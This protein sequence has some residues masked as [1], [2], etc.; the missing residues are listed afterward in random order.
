MNDI[1]GIQG[2]K[3]FKTILVAIIL[4]LRIE[5]NQ[6]NAQPIDSLK[7]EN[8]LNYRA[9]PYNS[10]RT[11][12]L[13]KNGFNIDEYKWNDQTI[14]LELKKA[15]RKRTGSK[16]WGVAALS[17][18]IIFRKD[19][20]FLLTLVGVSGLIA[21]SKNVKAKQV[22][23]KTEVL[24]SKFM[25]SDTIPK[26]IEPFTPSKI[27]LTNSLQKTDFKM[28]SRNGFESQNYRWEN[29]KINLYLNK[30]L[31]QN[32]AKKATNIMGITTLVIGLGG[33]YANAVADDRGQSNGNGSA[34]SFF[35][36]SGGFF[37]TSIILNG[38]TLRN[39]EI[40]KRL[41]AR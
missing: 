15:V 29:E 3:S 4:I 21:L 33:L 17:K 37:I 40:A 10:S 1:L 31:A 16:I 39:L 22:I 2:Y 34:S 24:R 6:L 32:N 36:L 19:G 23:K 28:L 38:A 26:Y 27:E 35:I 25:L 20:G 41:K 8:S 9:N 7:Q 18:A 11:K 13:N 30:S 14:N 12:W 5:P